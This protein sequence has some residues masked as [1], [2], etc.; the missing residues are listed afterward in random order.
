VTEGR[1][2]ARTERTARF[3]ELLAPKALLPYSSEF[4]VV[5]PQARRFARWATTGWWTDKEQA[6]RRYAS[7]TGR[8][9]FALFEGD[10]ARPAD[11]GWEVERGGQPRPTLHEVEEALYDPAPPTRGLFPPT[12]PAALQ[13][14]LDE[15]SA[16]LFEM[17]ATRGIET[18]WTLVIEPDDMALERKAVD[19]GARVLRAEPVAGAKVL[20]CHAEANYVAALLRN[21]SHWNTARISFNLRWTR[22]PNAYDHTL[23]DLLNF[24]HVP[25]AR[26]GSGA[27]QEM[28]AQP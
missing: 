12:T 22:V 4:A 25:R 16:R 15:A 3:I 8:P 13:G 18:D 24:L 21:D 23:Y 5:G 2:E 28:I 17:Q 20:T 10:V 26:K 19:F 14:L 6:A 9:A 7:L 1:E 11:A 27:V